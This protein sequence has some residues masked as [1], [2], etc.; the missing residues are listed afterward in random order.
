MSKACAQLNFTAAA[1]A[2][3]D[4]SVGITAFARVEAWGDGWYV[5]TAFC[6][7]RVD[8]DDIR[9]YVK[10]TVKPNNDVS[11]ATSSCN[12]LRTTSNS[13]LTNGHS[14]AS[15]W[16]EHDLNDI[17][18]KKEEVIIINGAGPWKV[19]NPVAEHSLPT[20]SGACKFAATKKTPAYAPNGDE[21]VFHGEYYEYLQMDNKGVISL[22]DGFKSASG[23]V[24]VE[25]K[26][27]GSMLYF[28]DRNYFYDSNY[29]FSAITSGTW[30][31]IAVSDTVGVLGMGTVSPSG[32]T[33][34][35]NDN[36][37]AAWG[38]IP[39]WSE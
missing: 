33:E 3:S 34:L 30:E 31:Y 25:Y 8:L 29:T 2:V 16:D 26:V 19:S 39:A 11:G 6:C 22:R 23:V 4:N 38:P 7:S 37:N 10:R 14:Y 15:G 20:I 13:V 28:T 18:E 36:V 1:D 12:L 5:Y 27:G 21:F 9:I 35:N 24:I 32:Q 17:G